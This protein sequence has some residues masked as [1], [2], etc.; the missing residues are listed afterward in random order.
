MVKCFLA[1]SVVPILVVLAAADPTARVHVLDAASNR[2]LERFNEIQHQIGHSP[3]H[4]AINF[5]FSKW[6]LFSMLNNLS[7]LIMHSIATSTPL[8]VQKWTLWP[9]SP[10]AEFERKNNCS[11]LACYIELPFDLFP[12]GCG[13]N[14]GVKE[15][16]N[17]PIHR[18]NITNF[19]HTAHPDLSLEQF[20]QVVHGWFFD[21]PTPYIKNVCKE[22]LS[23]L[24]LN[25][26]SYLSAHVRWGD[27]T[28][29]EAHRVEASDYAAAL[30]PLVT[31]TQI[32]TVFLATASHEAVGA[33]RLALQGVLPKV[34]MAVPDLTTRLLP[35]EEQNGWLK[36]GAPREGA[37]IEAYADV[38]TVLQGRGA[39]LT[40]SS[41]MGRW[42]Y[43]CKATEVASS[44]FF[45]ANIFDGNPTDRRSSTPRGGALV[46]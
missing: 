19:I 30:V 16:H 31:R 39:V 12:T 18:P 11:Y 21:N 14:V 33:M 46:A 22:R 20:R 38:W 44:A 25:R 4:G 9:Y 5:R 8:C 6:G 35:S 37:F 26:N 10:S 45:L 13:V 28:K 43:Y 34:R 2:L 36:Q 15:V 17:I 1:P 7:V 23:A 27:K 40:L 41:N 42:V 3:N 32:D 29:M 24:R